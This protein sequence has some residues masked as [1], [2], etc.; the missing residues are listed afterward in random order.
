MHQAVSHVL[1]ASP[2]HTPRPGLHPT[3]FVKPSEALSS[4]ADTPLYHRCCLFQ[5]YH[6]T[7]FFLQLLSDMSVSPYETAQ[8]WNH[9]LE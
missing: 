8:V 9:V 5:L 3:S 4:R 6:A 2:I 1:C 7:A